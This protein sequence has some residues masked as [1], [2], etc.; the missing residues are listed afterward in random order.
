MSNADADTIRYGLNKKQLK[1]ILELIDSFPEIERV[2]LF[3]SRADGT[4]KVGS[5]IDLAII[6]HQIT[7]EILNRFS[8][9]LDD[10]PL[11]FMFDVIDYNKI[12]N[13]YLKKNIDSK[14]KLL[15]E[16]KLNSV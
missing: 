3:G 6:G 4:N 8:S 5:D 16:R 15:F 1:L 13:N 14:G 7:P 12:L 9:G 10:L 2:F 11:P